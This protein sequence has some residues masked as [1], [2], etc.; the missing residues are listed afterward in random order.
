MPSLLMP[1]YGPGHH[2]SQTL[3]IAC[4]PTAGELSLQFY[5]ELN[6]FIVIA[7]NNEIQIALPLDSYT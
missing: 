2:N 1:R 4:V 3:A 6:A 5:F 7:Y